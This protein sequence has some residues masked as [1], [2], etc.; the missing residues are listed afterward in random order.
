VGGGCDSLRRVRVVGVPGKEARRE[1]RT[2]R[3]MRMGHDGP[4]HRAA[5]PL[6]ISLGSHRGPIIPSS[7]WSALSAP[8]CVPVPS[9]AISLA[10]LRSSPDALAVYPHSPAPR[11]RPFCP[12]R[13]RSHAA[14][15]RPASVPFDIYMGTWALEWKYSSARKRW[16]LLR[17]FLSLF[18]RH[19]RWS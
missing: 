5:V 1:E 19:L 12:P 9:R 16:L 2:A 13:P 7:D 8:S 10:P 6:T 4:T 14:P 11:V 15:T 17:F 18:S 3:S